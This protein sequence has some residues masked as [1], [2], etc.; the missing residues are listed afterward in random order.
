ME[1]GDSGKDRCQTA[2]SVFYELDDDGTLEGIR[3]ML[4]SSTSAIVVDL[5]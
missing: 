4:L 5:F 3:I 2:D 1:D